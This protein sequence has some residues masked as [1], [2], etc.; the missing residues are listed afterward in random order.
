[1]KQNKINWLLILQ[2]WAMLWVVVGHSGPVNDLESYPSYALYL[3]HFAYSFHMSLLFFVSGWLF[4]LTR[5]NDEASNKWRYGTMVADK[6]KHLGIPFVVF[7]IIAMIVK[8][9]FAS[10]V[11]RASSISLSEFVMAILVPY[12]GPLRELWFIGALI[13]MF[14]LGPVWRVSL[15]NNYGIALTIAVL[16]VLRYSGI[17]EEFLSIGRFCRFT[18]FFYCGILVCKHQI[19]E[20]ATHKIP[21]PFLLLLGITIYAIGILFGESFISAWGGVVLSVAISLLLDEYLPK[22]FSSFRNYTMQIYLMGLFGQMVVKMVHL[23]IG[24]GWLVFYII[25]MLIGL[26][27]PVA[28]AMLVEKLNWT[29]LLLCLGM[30]K[31]IK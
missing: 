29:P 3:Y 7:T 8:V 10:Q 23:H 19:I 25:S 4:Y 15:R 17:S 2:G 31:K 14:V 21:P 24:Y 16:V 9:T 30:K 1:M 13:W 11:E 22:A 5:L 6:L 28:I 27:M 26:Y 12:N 18:I 20:R